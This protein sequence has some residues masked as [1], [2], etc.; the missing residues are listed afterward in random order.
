[1]SKKIGK[2]TESHLLS[3]AEGVVKDKTSGSTLLDTDAEE[4]IPKFKLCGK[5]YMMMHA[6]VMSLLEKNRTYFHF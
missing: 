1:M 2:F 4:R 6:L 3:V 5:Y